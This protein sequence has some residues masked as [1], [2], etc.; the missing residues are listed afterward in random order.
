LTVERPSGKSITV[1]DLGSD[2]IDADKRPDVVWGTIE[3]AAPGRRSRRTHR[4]V[5]L[6]N[7]A[8]VLYKGDIA[9]CTYPLGIGYIAAVLLENGYEVEILDVFA[10]GF[11]TP[12]PMEADANF[13]RYGL[14]LAEVEHRIRDFQPHVVGV[15]SIFSNQSDNVRELLRIAKKVDPRIVTAIGGAHARYFPKACLEDANLDWV[16]L[17][18]SELTFYRFMEALNGDYPFDALNGVAFRDNAG[19]PVV[20]T[21]L[22]LIGS[23][24]RN[25]AGD[26][27]EIDQ[28]PFPAWRLYDME[29]YFRYKAY[30]SPYTIGSRVGQIYTSR[31]CSAKCTF[32]T[33]TNFWG[34]RLRRRSP[35]NVVEEIVRLR[36]TYAIDEFHI[37]DDNVTN[38]MNHAK[39]LFT[40]LIDV[41]LPWATPQGT[42]IWRMDEE[43][44][45]LMKA[46]GAYQITFAIE[47]GV[48]RV[49][50]QLI[51]KPLN[52]DRTIGLVRYARKIGLHVHGFFIIGMPPMFGHEGE[53]VEEMYQTYRY[54]QEAEFDSASFFTATPIVGS[55]LLSEA[56][57]QGFI[58]DTEPLYR[59][60]YK[61]GL[62]S[63]PG[64]WQGEEVAELAAAFNRDFN[65]DRA[66]R[67]AAQREWSMAEY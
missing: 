35:E 60:S 43:L 20:R 41:G 55:V 32:C 27:S 22:D 29:R 63:V 9:R 45:D 3:K 15:S 44:L 1:R 25:A 26:W 50:D 13:L 21:T 58:A 2:G 16:F 12:Q 66:R 10:E 59:M 28:I 31:G 36:D 64:L 5:M 14:D 42:A 67:Y 38:D 34:N 19:N 56:I 52:L 23:R 39:S 51:R 4:R 24:E 7:P 30:Q 53:T 54:A 18:E 57:R 49:L 6:L 11:E 65:A 62:L 40:Q 17:G 48:Q 46:S 8:A 47:S 33:T 37:Q 61:Q